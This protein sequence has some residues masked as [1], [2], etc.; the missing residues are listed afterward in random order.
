VSALQVPVRTRRV[1][2]T[3]ASVCRSWYS[4][5]QEPRSFAALSIRCGPLR[6][7]SASRLAYLARIFR[8][9]GSRCC[10]A[11]G[12]HGSAQVETIVL[13]DVPR[14]DDE[15]RR[16]AASCPAAHLL[17]SQC[18]YSLKETRACSH[19]SF[20]GATS[21]PACPSLR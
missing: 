17:R 6:R 8:E 13:S 11:G 18:R 12:V 10:R 9:V 7:V 2:H 14:I 19:W 4:L 3:V 5:S 21:S 16:A 20:C 1:A 15:A